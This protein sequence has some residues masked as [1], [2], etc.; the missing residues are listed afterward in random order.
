MRIAGMLLAAAVLFVSGRVFALGI[1]IG[2]VHVHGTKV[3]IGEETTLRIVV[4]KLKYEEKG[5]KKELKEIRAHRKGDSDDKFEIK[6]DK[7]DLN[8]DSKE[9]LAKIKEDK[10]YRMTIKKLDE[11][12]R[13]LK[14][15]VDEDD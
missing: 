12:W 8:E 9:V 11:G 14:I 5:D 1:D 15:K 2:P 7:E 13:L 3:K 4:D 6:V 10:R